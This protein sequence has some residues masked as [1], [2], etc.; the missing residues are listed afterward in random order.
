M[1][2]IEKL[3]E[4]AAAATRGA[5]RHTRQGVI[6]AGPFRQ[7]TN[8]SAQ[9]QIASFCVTSHEDDDEHQTEKQVPNALFSAAA[10]PDTVLELIAMASAAAPQVVA[11]DGLVPLSVDG[12]SVWLEGIGAVALDY[13]SVKSLSD[14][15]DAAAP[16]QA[17][18]P[19]AWRYQPKDGLAHPAY[20]ERYAQALAYDA[21]PVPLYRAPVQPVAVPDDAV[22]KKALIAIRDRCHGIGIRIS[23]DVEKMAIAAL[24]APAAQGDAVTLQ[25]VRE[26]VE[27]F[28]VE[29]MKV[30]YFA[31]RV[32]KAT[33]EQIN[34]A[35]SIIVNIPCIIDAAIAAKAAS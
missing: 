15:Q 31:D 27:R 5:W 21:A 24:A 8:G 16:V 6:V 32:N 23:D 35:T 28:K 17:Q 30:P 11:D 34:T 1:I 25:K 29:W 7:Y 20:T 12:K 14:M 4:L 13:S 10:C 2:D 26:A 3:K 9:S 22:L 19:V 18:E 33:R